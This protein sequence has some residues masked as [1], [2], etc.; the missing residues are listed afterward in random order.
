MSY[1]ARRDYEESCKLATRVN[2]AKGESFLDGKV[3]LHRGDCL[4]VLP[5]LEEDSVDSVVCD[6]PYHLTSIV[7]RFGSPT[8]APVKSNMESPDG[9]PPPQSAAPLRRRPAKLEHWC[10]RFVLSTEI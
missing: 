8:A 9:A 2:R 6:P 10:T 5:L 1:D 3:T 7:K 4:E